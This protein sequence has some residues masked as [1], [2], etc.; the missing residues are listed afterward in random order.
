MNQNSLLKLLFMGLAGGGVALNASSFDAQKCLRTWL[1][2]MHKNQM[3]MLKIDWGQPGFCG[4][5][6]RDYDPRTHSCG[7]RGKRIQRRYRD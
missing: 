3:D 5:F 4:E 2:Q 7:E 1:I 6:D